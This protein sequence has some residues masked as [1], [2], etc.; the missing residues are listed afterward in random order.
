MT[1]DLIEAARLAKAALV[2]L[3]DALDRHRRAQ[4]ALPG[5]AADLARL[6]DDAALSAAWRLADAGLMLRRHLEAK[7]LQATGLTEPTGRGAT[8]PGQKPKGM[9]VTAWTI[10]KGGNDL[11]DAFT[12][13]DDLATAR[14]FYQDAVALPDL[15][16]AAIAQVIE[17]TEPHWMDGAR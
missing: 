5:K 12:V 16:C 9:F 8:L 17:A 15:H 14:A 2:C 6:A 3:N 11:P 1:A 7:G 13:S 10:N 4:S